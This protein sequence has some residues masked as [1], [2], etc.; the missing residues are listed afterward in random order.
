M[1]SPSSSMQSNSGHWPWSPG[2]VT[3]VFRFCPTRVMKLSGDGI[4][5]EFDAI[6]LGSLALEPR[7]CDRGFPLLSPSAH[8]I[9]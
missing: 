4:T 3:G 8:S 1:K 2:R 7:S 9:T 5:I 6:E